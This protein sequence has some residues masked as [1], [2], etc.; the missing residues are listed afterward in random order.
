M[1]NGIPLRYTR[2]LYKYGSEVLRFYY[3]VSS[4]RGSKKIRKE[5]KKRH[6]TTHKTC[7]HIMHH[8]QS[9]SKRVHSCN[10]VLY[11]THIKETI[12]SNFYHFC[13]RIIC[14]KNVIRLYFLFGIMKLWYFKIDTNNLNLIQQ[15]LYLK[16]YIFIFI[17]V[18]YDE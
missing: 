6:C 13:V 5:R 9:R 2:L 17:D 11:D 15:L 7:Y 10:A 14:S 18:E 8:C 4:P 16:I 1:N 3:V 12:Y